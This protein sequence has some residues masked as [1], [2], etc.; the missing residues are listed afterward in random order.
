MVSDPLHKHALQYYNSVL[1]L[2]H[3][4]FLFLSGVHTLVRGVDDPKL[5]IEDITWLPF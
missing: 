1:S 3:N 4:S 2:L 5:G